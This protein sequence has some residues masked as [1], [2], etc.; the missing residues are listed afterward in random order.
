M[1][2]TQ[3][4]DIPVNR[5]LQIDVP[6]E[7]PVGKTIISFTP[8]STARKRMT[9]AEE[10]ELINRNAERLNRETMDILSYQNWFSEPKAL[11][12]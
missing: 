8:A 7:V 5:K 12:T 3:T 4:V 1:T 10:I 9:E 6:R 2:I 11:D